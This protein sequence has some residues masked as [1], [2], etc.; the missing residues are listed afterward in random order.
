MK[1]D[2]LL[3]IE[4]GLADADLAVAGEFVPDTLRNALLT[5]GVFAAVHVTAPASYS[6]AL[7]GTPGFSVRSDRDDVAFWKRLFAETGADHI[8][9]VYA[10]SP[11]LDPEIIRD[12]LGVHLRYL[13]EFTYSE[14]LPRGY[15]CE[16]I[17]HELVKSVPESDGTMLPLSEVVRSNINQF[18]VELYYRDPDIRE[19]RLSFR[20][21]DRRER[22][23][24]EN[25]L[26]ITGKKPSYAEIGDIITA[27]PQALHVGPSYLEIEL[28][29]RCDLDCVFCFRK[30]LS[31]ERGDMQTS[32]FE[33]LI[34][35][36]ASF[37]LPYSLCFGG[38]GEPL[39]HGSFFEL[40][41][42]A[43]CEP[44]LKNLILETNG[45]LAGENFASFVRSAGDGRLR[46]IVNLNAID[47]ATYAALH[48]ADHF[49]RVHRNVLALREALP[50]KESLYVQI[51]KIN[52]TEPFL[53]R[54]YDAWEKNGVAI[55]LQKQNTYLG[56]I[57]DR[58][59]SDLS[60]LERIPCWHLQRDCYV[61]SS[62]AVAF[63][64]Q[65]VDGASARGTLANETLQAVWEKSR[66]SFVR[67]YKGELSSR[68][69]CR[70]CDEW[71]TFNL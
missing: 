47:P 15:S 28:T 52:E 13:A 39:M 62:G 61:L 8:A 5:L 32:V 37:G 14:N 57:Q 10:D 64:R 25:I 68:P 53:D 22:R 23:I 35:G 42:R 56:M 21:G 7:A 49:E 51:L 48:G 70:S 41:S 20:S 38:S 12:M 33:R 45:L 16:I 66:E 69:D 4:D 29:G 71:Y 60:P 40:T 65:D 2:A 24:I 34:E 9:L 67:D 31:A 18:D 59:Y 17:S 50:A 46:V 43:L 36:L 27:N 58:R 63:C 44:L 26:S 54:Y 55:I 30:K 11:L 6:G 19:K 1:V 3:Y